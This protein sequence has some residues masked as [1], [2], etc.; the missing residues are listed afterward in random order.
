MSSRREC[1]INARPTAEFGMGLRAV[2]AGTL[3]WRKYPGSEGVADSLFGGG[4]AGPAKAP[5]GP[6]GNPDVRKRSHIAFIWRRRKCL[7]V[8]P[9]PTT[10][11]G[12][13]VFA[14]VRGPAVGV[15]FS[16][17]ERTDD[18]FLVDDNAGVNK[19]AV[20]LSGQTVGKKPGFQLL[21]SESVTD[22][23]TESKK[24]RE[25]SGMPGGGGGSSKA[26]I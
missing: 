11:L 24:I 14:V 1:E 17:F 15:E 3:T 10:N 4:N 6:V 7:V 25:C 2:V 16:G 26:L 5:P 23:A 19:A 12:V 21:G 9:R 13:R 20:C 8:N 22:I 18:D